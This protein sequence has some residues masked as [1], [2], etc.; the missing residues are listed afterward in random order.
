M[1]NPNKRRAMHVLQKEKQMDNHS[2]NAT[3]EFPRPALIPVNGV[4][5]EVF[6][7]GRQNK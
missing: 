1:E 4:E 7:V 6:E 3:S 5:L 2:A